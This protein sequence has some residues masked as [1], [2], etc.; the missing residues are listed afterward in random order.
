M[1]STDKNPRWVVSSPHIMKN[2][3]GEY[4]GEGWHV[5]RPH[6]REGVHSALE[7]IM[8]GKLVK[9]FRNEKAAITAANSLNRNP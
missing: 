7:Y 4:D 2:D 5:C 3:K 8:D 9:F 1:K 6:P